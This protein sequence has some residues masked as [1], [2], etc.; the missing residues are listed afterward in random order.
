MRRKI[1]PYRPDLKELARK[2]RNDSTLGEV[3]LWNKLKC[4][5][6]FSFDFQRQKPLLDYI[7]DFYCSELNLVIEIDGV[8]HTYEEKYNLDL[9]RDEKLRAYDLTILRFS[10][11]EVKKDIVNV[12]RA[13]E[14]YVVEHTP[15]PSQEGNFNSL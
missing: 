5:Q 15:N 8:Y 13:L 11:H 4:K 10:E 9:L 1:I 3:L 7:V 2:L 14:Q 12:L 6:F